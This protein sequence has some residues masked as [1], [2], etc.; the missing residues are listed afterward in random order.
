MLWKI[1][2]SSSLIGRNGEPMSFFAPDLIAP[3]STPIFWSKPSVDAQ[4]DDSHAAGHACRVGDDLIGG[5]GDV[6]PAG[7][8]DIHD[9]G[10]NGDLVLRFEFAD[11]VMDED[12]CRD[13]PTGAVD[14]KE[15]RLD[16]AVLGG[17]RQV[18]PDA[19]DRI[20]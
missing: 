10:H 13:G 3:A 18:L 12:R 20:F 19:G 5:D 16:M 8:A 2:R 6:V 7:G 14:P 11:L 9:G 1:A 15:Q 17:H 4:H